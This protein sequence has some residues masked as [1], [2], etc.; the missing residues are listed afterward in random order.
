M[1]I[2]AALLQGVNVGKYKRITMADFK[3]IITELGGEGATTVAN[4]GNVVFRHDDS[5]TPEDLRVAI[6][7]AVSNHVGMAV[8][9]I[10]RSGEEMRQVVA[11]N[12]YPNVID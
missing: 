4:S 6:E 8:P 1:A 10:T 2:T 11:A 7:N 5:R 9:T 12:P 3:Q